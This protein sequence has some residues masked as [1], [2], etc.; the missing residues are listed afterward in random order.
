MQPHDLIWSTVRAKLLRGVGNCKYKNSRRKWTLP[1]LFTHSWE[2]TDF[3]GESKVGLE[4]HPLKHYLSNSMLKG[5]KLCWERLL[6]SGVGL[7]LWLPQCF[8]NSI[9]SQRNG[10]SS[11]CSKLH[12][13]SCSAPKSLSRN[14]EQSLQRLLL[15]ARSARTCE[16]LA[17]GKV[18]GHLCDPTAG[19]LT[20]QMFPAVAGNT[21]TQPWPWCFPCL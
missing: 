6:W 1:H 7:P 11:H 12:D 19:L 8:L 21:H 16:L 10:N 17:K 15:P 18:L 3:I 5:V 9:K 14:S 4:L 13:Q 2:A 20:V